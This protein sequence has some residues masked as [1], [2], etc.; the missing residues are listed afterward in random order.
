M[1]MGS[2]CALCGGPVA[3]SL[4]RRL[5]SL[6][7]LCAEGLPAEMVKPL[8]TKVA[9]L[10]EGEVVLLQTGSGDLVNPQ[11]L[12]GVIVVALFIPLI[13]WGWIAQRNE[14]V[15]GA[16]ML[17]VLIFLVI[18]VALYY[19]SWHCY[20]HRRV[21]VTSA[22]TIYLHGDFRGHV[23]EIAHTPQVIA[24]ELADG[25]RTHVNITARDGELNIP[26][27]RNAFALCRLIN[28]LATDSGMPVLAAAASAVKP[29]PPTPV[30]P[31]LPPHS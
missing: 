6:C 12:A 1:T 20:H 16:F 2:G 27:V 24:V 13:T 31:P 14:P 19:L 17:S 8:P 3:E 25:N 26:G 15:L 11:S 9:P 5:P 21:V 7:V 29:S 10:A 4:T 30:P 22:R 23:T 18:V 28:A